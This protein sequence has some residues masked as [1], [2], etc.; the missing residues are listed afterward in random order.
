L[1]PLFLAPTS[2]ADA[3]PPALIGAAAAAGYDGIGLRLNASPGLPFHPVIGNAAL[4]REIRRALADSGLAVLD[5]Y[6]FYLQPATDIRDFTP[7]LELG[8][9]LGAKYALTMGDDPE[10]PRLADNFGRFCD[11]AAQFGLTCAVEFAVMRRIASLPQA[12]RLVTGSGR[13]N[14]VICLDPLN[15][16]RGGGAPGDL[17][18]LDPRLLPYA[19]ITDGVLGPGEPDPALLGR[20]SPNRRCLLGKGVVPIA[21]ILDALPAGLP[22]SVELPPA[23]GAQLSASEW[24][25]ATAENVRGFLVEYYRARSSKARNLDQ[26][27]GFAGIPPHGGREKAGQ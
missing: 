26:P 21:A 9:A 15:L 14:A 3:A 22:L 12:A 27:A 16:V 13:A 10:W 8:A 5:V 24:A 6:S 2:L 20:M 4:I 7:A 18:A 11:A 19:Q 25:K 1:N 17:A 23:P